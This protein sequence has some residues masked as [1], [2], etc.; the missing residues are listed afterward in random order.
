[1]VPWQITNAD[2]PANSFSNARIVSPLG[3]VETKSIPKSVAN[4]TDSGEKSS[5]G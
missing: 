4:P 2:V 5:S 3:K 1:V